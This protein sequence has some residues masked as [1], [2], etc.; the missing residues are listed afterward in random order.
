VSLVITGSVKHYPWGDT[1]F[2]PQLLGIEPDGRPWAELWL[3]THPAGPAVLDGGTP[4]IDETGPLPYLLKVLAAAEPLS[5]QAHPNAAQAR[6]GY[7]R[8]VFPDP[9]PKPE[10]LMALTSFDALCGIRPIEPTGRLLRTLGLG[11]LADELGRCGPG[12]LLA[13]LYRGEI[14]VAPIVEACR[15]SELPEARLVTQLD[16]RYPGEPSVAV[17]LLLNR[18]RLEP[19]EALHL[20]AGNLHAYLGGA[21]I[22]LMGAS[23]NVVRGGLTTKHVDIDELLDV[24]DATPLAE[25]VINAAEASGRYPLPEAG[26]ELRRISPGNSHRSVGD[27]LAVGL[28]GTTVYLPPGTEYRPIAETYVVTSP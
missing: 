24:V 17:T 1:A 3:G 16:D 8:G 18:V 4:L 14:A 2:I 23:D 10:L 15:A 21:G 25:P 6:A 11:K 7:E 22:E 5:L 19:G 13:D 28:D 20:T 12:D 26:C 9:N 27:E